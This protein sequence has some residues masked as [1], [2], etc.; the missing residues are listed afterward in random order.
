MVTAFFTC[1]RKE[2]CDQSNLNRSFSLVAP[3]SDTLNA[4]RSPSFK[5]WKR[6]ESSVCKSTFFRRT[7]IDV[8]QFH[9][10][11]SMLMFAEASKDAMLSKSCSLVDRSRRE[12]GEWTV[13]RSDRSELY[14]VVSTPTAGG[15][16]T[17]AD[18]LLNST[19]VASNKVDVDSSPRLF[20]MAQVF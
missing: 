14:V 20:N 13:A 7:C 15:D 2:S 10:V 18:T 5:A 12:I 16:I 11:S 17:S 4:A 6:C 9:C 3:S 1:F 8:F 19:T